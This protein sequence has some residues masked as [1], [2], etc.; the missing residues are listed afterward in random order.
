MDLTLS[1]IHAIILLLGWNWSSRLTERQHIMTTSPKAPKAPKAQDCADAT[2]AK[3]LGAT[4]NETALRAWFDDSARHMLSGNLSARGWNATVEASNSSTVLRSTWGAYVLRAFAIGSLKGG[5][6][7][8]VKKLVT[9]TQDAAR[10]FKAEEFKS[11]IESAKSYA[12]FVK[13]I[14]ARAPK[15]ANAQTADEKAG[16]AVKAVA[17]D[18]DA[19]VTLALGLLTELEGDKALPVNIEQAE[20]LRG[21]IAVQIRN[22]KAISTPNH[23]AVANA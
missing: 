12:D 13:A 9:T 10:A 15:G 2:L 16:A 8:S 14:P 17:V 23:P 1:L 21:F 19:V 5:E 22:A 18:F 11:A 20:R 4:V 7:V 3:A 6:K